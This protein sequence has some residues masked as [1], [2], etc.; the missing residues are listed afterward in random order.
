MLKAYVGIASQKGLAVLQ[1]ERNDTL[2]LIEKS[3]RSSRSR[4][5]FWAVIRETDATSVEQLF[6]CG[7]QK[8][9]LFMLERCAKEIG[10]IIPTVRVQTRLH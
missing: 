8:E 9:A 4:I 1:P 5:G 3:I 7:Y 2:Q 6:L 10:R